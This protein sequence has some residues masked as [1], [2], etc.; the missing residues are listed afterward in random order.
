MFPSKNGIKILILTS[1]FAILTYIGA[2]IQV[3]MYPAPISLQTLFVMFAGLLLG[4]KYGV[5]SQLLYIFLGLLGLPIFTGGGG[6]GYVLT[7][8]F[9]F[10]IGFL[11]L[12]Y[13]SGFAKGN[14]FKVISMLLLG[15]L[16]LYCI[17][18]TYL[19]FILNKIAGNDLSLITLLKGMTIYLPGDLL[20]IFI[21]IPIALKIRKRLNI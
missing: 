13:F 6:I 20:K 11:P 15:N 4:S 21:T 10:I 3:P 5:L 19:W 2:L 8:T 1:F 17:G 18:I 7:P 12:A 14:N 16:I 9:G